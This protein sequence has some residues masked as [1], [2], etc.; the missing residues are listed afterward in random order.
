MAYRNFADRTRV[1]YQND[2]EDFIEFAE[3]SGVIH[4]KEVG[5]PIV[6]RYIAGQEQKGYSSLTRKR[7]VVTIRSFLMFLYQDGYIHTNVGSKIILPFTESTTPHILTQGECDQ[8]RV[9]CTGNTRDSAIIEVLLQ[10]GIRLSELINLTVNDFDLGNGTDERVNGY[11][12][13]VGGRGRKDRIVPLN[14]KAVFALREYLDGKKPENGILFSNRF[15][16][17]LGERGVQKMLRKY[18]K[19]AGIA[20]AS[21]STL[22]HTFGAE[23]MINGVSLKTLKE[24]MGLKDPRSTSIYVPFVRDQENKDCRIPIAIAFSR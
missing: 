14:A 22:R 13:I 10:T 21:I 2:L 5:L 19:Q 24:I 18:L 23:H 11:V 8:L 4:A 20:E 3:K 15:G 9:A 17:P 7:K 1:E 16:K 12:R 6:E